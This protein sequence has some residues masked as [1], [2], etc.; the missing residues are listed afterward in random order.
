MIFKKGR[1][2]HTSMSIAL[3]ASLA[4]IALAMWG[5]DLPAQTVLTFLWICLVLVLVVIAAAALLLAIIKLP[6]Y[7]RD[8]NK[9]SD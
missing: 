6:Q 7:W 9:T 3:L 5:W 4:F 2:P 8:R 1:Q